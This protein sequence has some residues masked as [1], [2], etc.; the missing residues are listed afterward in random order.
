MSPR[1]CRA[2]DLRRDRAVEL[3]VFF[4]Y[5]WVWVGKTPPKNFRRFAAKKPFKKFRRE[6]AILQLKYYLFNQNVEYNCCCYC[7]ARRRRENLGF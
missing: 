5:F 1:R 3:P 2:C 4:F 6:A 7:L